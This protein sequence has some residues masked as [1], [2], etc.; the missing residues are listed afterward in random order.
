MNQPRG[1]KNNSTLCTMDKNPIPLINYC[2]IIIHSEIILPSKELGRARPGWLGRVYIL[3]DYNFSFLAQHS[4]RY[5]CH[6]TSTLIC[7][8]QLARRNL[9][10]QG[11]CSPPLAQG[12]GPRHCH[13]QVLKTAISVRHR[14]CCRHH[15]LFCKIKARPRSYRSYLQWHPWPYSTQRGVE[16][17]SH[18]I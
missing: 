15:V 6:N 12:R 2:L 10:G 4:G 13:K 7:S 18:L 14:C 16:A 1:S 5:Q 8:F 17:C 3:D 11:D 9:Q